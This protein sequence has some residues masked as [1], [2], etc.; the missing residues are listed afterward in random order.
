MNLRCDL[1][2]NGRQKKLVLASQ[3]EETFDHLALKLAAYLFFWKEEPVA[4]PSLKHPALLGQEFRPALMALNDSGEVRLWIECGH[5]SLNKLDKLTRRFPHAR[6]V[7]LKAT[8]EEG[9]RL[10]RDLTDKEVRR[11]IDIWA[12]PGDS[13]R[14]WRNAVEEKVEVFGETQEHMMN[15]TVN[16]VPLAVD[17][18]AC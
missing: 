11:W 9:R 10:R 16:N 17:L 1:H 6:W 13:F 18:V 12:W 7:V 4:D 5:V 15:L 3:P 14:Q 2:V 8:P